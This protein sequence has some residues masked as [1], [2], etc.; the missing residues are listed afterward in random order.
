MT[1][2]STELMR[3]NVQ[4][5]N[6]YLD[7]YS[8]ESWTLFRDTPQTRKF[9]AYYMSRLLDISHDAYSVRL[10]C[11]TILLVKVPKLTLH[12]TNKSIFLSNWLRTLVE[13]K[14][15]LQYQHQLTSALLNKDPGNLILQNLPFV[16]GNTGFF[17]ITRS[18]FESRRLSLISCAL[19]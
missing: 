15:M 18:E 12:E 5:W 16:M 13:R 11:C 14:S 19:P 8:R 1:T 9:T 10:P 7:D 4:S 2:G 3:Y 17:C 6:M